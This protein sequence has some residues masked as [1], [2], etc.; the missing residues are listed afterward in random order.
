MEL[1]KSAAKIVF[2]MMTVAVIAGLFIGKVE[3]KDFMVLASMVF[4][5]YFANKGETTTGETFGAGK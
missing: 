3:S 5:F 2:L 4:V 1:L